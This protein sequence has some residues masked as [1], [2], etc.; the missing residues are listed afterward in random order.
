MPPPVSP[1]LGIT[2]STRVDSYFPGLLDLSQGFVL[3][4]TALFDAAAAVFPSRALPTA[5]TLFQL[6]YTLPFSFLPSSFVLPF[7]LS[8][9]NNTENLPRRKWIVSVSPTAIESSKI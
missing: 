2:L 4:D 1:G 6:L 9:H 5:S 7:F 8:L 3:S